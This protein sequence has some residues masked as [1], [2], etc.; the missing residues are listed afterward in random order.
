MADAKIAILTP[1]VLLVPY[2]HHHVPTYHDWMQDEVWNSAILNQSSLRYLTTLKE[3]QQAT[4]SEPLSLPEEYAMQKSWRE[5]VDK[6]TFI[7][8]SPPLN[9]GGANSSIAPGDC[10]HPSAMIGDVNLF[11]TPA[12]DDEDSSKTGASSHLLGE[13]EIMIALK[14]SQGKGLGKAILLTFMWYIFSNIV[15]ILEEYDTAHEKKSMV[16]SE[17]RYL[18]VKIGAS[19]TRSI[20]LF[21][22]VG[23]KKISE[24]PNYFGEVELRRSVEDKLNQGEEVPRL[25]TYGKE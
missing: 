12:D 24:T 18:R 11:L 13:I 23:F 14:N 7:V 6:L 5:D 21:E 15:P 19:N 9:T 17:L 1:K 10:D 3:L 22:G 8:C 16:K 25:L 2:S 4:A 20:R